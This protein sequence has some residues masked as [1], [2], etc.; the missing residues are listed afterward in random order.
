MLTI[1]TDH[2][3]DLLNA[4]QESPVLYVATD[5]DDGSLSLDTWAEAL[6]PHHTVIVH[7][8]DLVDLVGTEPDEDHL[9]GALPELQQ[10]VEETVTRLS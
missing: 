5:T 10:T 3:R 8:S 2:L 7:R 6:V 1:T 4:G 9:A